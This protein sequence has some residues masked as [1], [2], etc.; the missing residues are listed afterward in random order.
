[1]D[2]LRLDASVA[3]MRGVRHALWMT[4][5]ALEGSAEGQVN[6]EQLRSDRRS[7]P[8]RAQ[9]EGSFTGRTGNVESIV[10][11][12]GAIGAARTGRHGFF[13]STQADYARFGT[14]ITVSKSFVHLRYDYDILGWLMAEAY[15]Q[16]QQDKFQRLQLREL[17]GLGPRFVLADEE[18]VRLACGTSYMLE[19]EKISVQT[20]APDPPETVVHR[21]SNYV[22]TTWRA[23]PRVRFVATLYLQPRFDFVED[24]RSLLE[25]SLVTDVNKRLAVKILATFRYDS[26]PPTGVKTT[27][28][29][30][31]SSFVL[32]F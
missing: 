24:V 23:D 15:V 20:G 1:M 28:A 10:V 14:T 3:K 2:R 27:D 32:K 30:V 16:Q 21:L 6:V 17:V 26:K 5:L 4:L 7:A 13:G 9:I 8:A 29:E 31:K 25:T 12:G 11:G 18:E 22:T 19:Y